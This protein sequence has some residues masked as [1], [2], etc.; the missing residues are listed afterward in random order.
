M[1]ELP[2]AALQGAAATARASSR[3]VTAPPVRDATESPAQSTQTREPRSGNREAASRDDGERRRA[4]SA[5]DESR[6]TR[7]EGTEKGDRAVASEREATSAAPAQRGEEQTG[8]QASGAARPFASL[9][10]AQLEF[11]PEDEA[12]S[13][14]A[15]IPASVQELLSEAP[16]AVLL[17]GGNGLPP[18]ALEEAMARHA[19][20]PVATLPTADKPKVADMRP[21][22]APANTEIATE[23]PV[24]ETAKKITEPAV[25]PVV[26]DVRTPAAVAQD[27]RA[28]LPT[29]ALAN[30]S[31]NGTLASSATPMTATIEVPLGQ[32]RWAQA[33]G[34]RVAWMVRDGARLASLRLDPPHLGP[35]EVRVSVSNGEASLSFVSAHAPVREA[36]EAAL[37]RLREMLDEQGLGL[38]NVDVSSRERGDDNQPRRGGGRS[39]AGGPDVDVEHGDEG[40]SAGAVATV[41]TRQGLLDRYA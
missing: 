30:G 17:P 1:S 28:V 13:E 40:E 3:T 34:E 19:A 20:P 32:P 7:K 39:N 10:A 25:A 38:G 5:R 29:I 21:G 35:V 16:P 37:P 2:L 31:G 14:L 4:A 18:A 23:L 22:A 12:G 8:Q 6:D 11:N 9:L 36:I 15:A 27:A 33:F 41:R 26:D 24:V